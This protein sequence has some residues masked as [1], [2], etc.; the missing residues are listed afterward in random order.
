M[1][2]TFVLPG[3]FI[4]GGVRVVFEYANRLQKKGHIVNVVYPLIPLYLKPKIRIRDRGAQIIR[5]L[6][7]INNKTEPKWNLNARLIRVTTIN[8][9]YTKYL[10]KS[11]PDADVIIATSWGTAYFVN[12][13][14]QSK[15]EKYYFVQS[16]E[17]WDIWQNEICWKKV[18]Q[19]EKDYRKWTFEMSFIT[20]N[21]KYLKESKKLVDDTY[22]MPNLKKI[23]IATWL[24][25]LLEIRFNQKVYGMITNGVNFEEFYCEEIP[26]KWEEKQKTITI[27]ASIRG[28]S[29][30]KGDF[31]LIESLMK[32]NNKHPEIKIVLYGSKGNMNIPE[33]IQFVDTPFGDKLRQLYCSAQIFVSASRLEGCQ[34]P[35]MEAMVCGCAVVATNVG[36]VPDYA[37]DGETILCAPSKNPEILSQ[38]IIQLIENEGLRRRIAENGH[39]H[40][41]QFNWDNA[42]QEFENVLMKSHKIL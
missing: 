26:S 31:D 27:L 14:S 5:T 12:N 37:I 40:I 33:W 1:K 28:G 4:G 30:L 13:L 23:T 38:K 41:K 21:D 32:V 36:G 19:I 42:T 35:P 20:P 15:G 8:H 16:Y 18:E 34:L 22:T 2:I 39:N 29:L 11:I 24:K 25:D 6:Y 17:I 7:N 3:I 10:E 9:K